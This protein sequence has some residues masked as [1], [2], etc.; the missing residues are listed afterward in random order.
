[1]DDADNQPTMSIVRQIPGGEQ[2]IDWFHGRLEF[3]DAEVVELR[4][5]R[6]EPS[7]LRIW[8]SI[9]ARERYGGPPFKTALISFMLRDVLDVAIQGFSHQNVI[10][11]LKIRMAKPM[12]LHP[13]LLGI[14]LH[15]PD[16]EIE[17]EPCA[18]AFGVI[19]ATIE[20]IAIEAAAAC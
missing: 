18:G 5:M 10:S 9:S 19:R 8:Q 15:F 12:Q 2:L 11:G 4:L 13:S 3:G 20:T 6:N 7:I 17:L 1:M 14:G 16:H